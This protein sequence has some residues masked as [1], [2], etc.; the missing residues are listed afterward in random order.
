MRAGR[1]ARGEEGTVAAQAVPAGSTLGCRD[2][3]KAGRAGG[4]QEL[5]PCFGKVC[6]HVNV[7]KSASME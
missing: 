5:S 6:S 1:V 7:Q 3:G 4:S 2:V